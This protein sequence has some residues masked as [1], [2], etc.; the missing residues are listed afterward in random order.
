MATTDI[1]GRFQ[2][3]KFVTAR[4][5]ENPK[6]PKILF[7]VESI[8]KMVE[9]VVKVAAVLAVTLELKNVFS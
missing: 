9:S 8:E 3:K 7:F 4:E 6:K 2:I 1:Q 5:G